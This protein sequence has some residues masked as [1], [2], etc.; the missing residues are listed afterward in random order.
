LAKP[1][2]ESIRL[3]RIPCDKLC[4]TCTI[5][6]QTS[7][8][9]SRILGV[10]HDWLETIAQLITLECHIKT[11]GVIVFYCVFQAIRLVGNEPREEATEVSGADLSSRPY[12]KGGGKGR[13]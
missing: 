11:P 5:D 13:I 6:G 12:E 10:L 9:S 2:R 1:G 3:Q 7:G 4:K 8:E